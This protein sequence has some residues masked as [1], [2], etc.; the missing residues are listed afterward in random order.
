MGA[1]C[2]D[3]SAASIQDDS[4]EMPVKSYWIE[5]D[6]PFPI[7]PNVRTIEGLKSGFNLVIK[8]CLDE[9]TWPIWRLLFS[10]IIPRCLCNAL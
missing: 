4:P 7:Q 2:A 8:C 10:D 5:A 1:S 6:F 9:K 3:A